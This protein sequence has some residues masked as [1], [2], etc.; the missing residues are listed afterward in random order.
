M[1]MENCWEA[2]KCKREPGGDKADEL[3][4]CP[5]AEE[6]CGDGI[7]QGTNSGRICWIVG[8]TLCGGEVQGSQAAKMDNCKDCDFYKKVQEE[9][10]DNFEPGI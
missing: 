6:K 3:G 8:G 5:A 7:N 10:G 4:V 2:K 1:I 9:E